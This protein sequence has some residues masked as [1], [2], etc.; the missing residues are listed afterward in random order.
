MDM[1]HCVQVVGYAYMSETGED[2]IEGNESRS[3]SGS[4]SGDDEKREG[5]WI[6]RNQWGKSW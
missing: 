2:D 6:V 3:G 4:N 5:Y 1:N